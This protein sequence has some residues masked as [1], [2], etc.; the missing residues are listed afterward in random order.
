MNLKGSISIGLLMMWAVLSAHAQLRLP[1]YFSNHAVL[2]RDHPIVLW[3]WSKPGEEVSVTMAGKDYLAKADT[4]S[5]WQ[6]Q[7]PATSAGGPYEIKVSGEAESITVNDIYFGDVYFCSGQ[8]NMAFLMRN[9][10][11]NQ[12][13][14]E[15]LPLVRQ[16]FVY[17]KTAISPQKEVSRAEW[18]MT[19]A[20]NFNRLSA[21]AHYFAKSIHQQEGIPIGIIH[22][23]WGGAPIET[24]MSALSLKDFEEATAKVEKIT[25]EFIT[26]TRKSNEQLRKA[27]PGVR[28]PKGFVNIDNRY[29]TMVYNGMIN[30]FFAYPVKGVIWYQGEAN[31]VVPLC[32]DYEAMLT[33]LI[34]SWR[35]SWKDEEL[36]FFVV[37]LANYGKIIDEP[38]SSGW[39]MVQEAQYNVSKRMKRVSTVVINDLGEPLDIHPRN[40]RDVG[41]RLAASALSM[42]YGHEN[43][44]VEGPVLDKAVVKGNMFELS[45]KNVGSGLVAKDGGDEL[46]A[47]AL[48]GEDNIF[49]RAT[50]TLNGNKVVVHSKDVPQPVHVRYAFES[51]PEKINFYNNEGFP[52]VPFRTDQLKDAKKRN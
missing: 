43:K 30:P 1:H 5:I 21:V 44:T 52:A 31:S 18:K 17:R 3:G 26:S 16:L 25:P 45:F 35:K 29:P 4:D 8:S 22:S 51:S 2:Q 48:A 9:E 32:Y 19:E 14:K 38:E 20:S 11:Y 12:E 6:V 34:T 36:P 49:Y 15:P 24:F 50:A 28:N 33:G 23:S 42:I 13:E 7:L 37:Q 40:K 41:K 10:Q 47:F 39:A 27:N 46:Y